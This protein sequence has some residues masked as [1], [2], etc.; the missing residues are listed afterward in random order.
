M[1]FSIYD[2]GNLPRIIEVLW[3]PMVQVRDQVKVAVPK[4]EPPLSSSSIAMSSDK[5]RSTKLKFKGEKTKKKRK[6]EDGDDA[7]GS[8]S[9]RRKGEDD[10]APET[11]VLP[12]NPNEIRGPTSFCIHLTHHLSLST[13]ILL[14]TALF[15]IHSTRKS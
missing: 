13:L 8:S 14:E 1:Y 6:R 4:I 11:W 3:K 2:D 12:E 15:C 10:K 5:V 9:T 7:G